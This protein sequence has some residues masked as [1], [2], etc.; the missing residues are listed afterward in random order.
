[1]KRFSSMLRSGLAVAALVVLPMT[2]VVA[3]AVFWEPPTS[4]PRVCDIPFTGGNVRV[5]A[6][7]GPV[8]TPFPITTSCPVGGGTCLEWRYQWQYTG[9]NPSQS[10]V[11]VDSNVRVLAAPGG[12]PI[13]P[14]TFNTSINYGN[15]GS[16]LGILYTSNAST[17]NAS[18]FTDTSA[19]IGTVTSG[20]K[21]GNRNGFCAIAG[22]NK[23]SSGNPDLSAPIAVVTTTGTCKVEWA[24]SKDGC[25][26]GVTVLPGS[27][28]SC[29]AIPSANG[30]GKVNLQN[31]HNAS[32]TASCS[33]EINAPGSTN[34]CRYNS[35]L[36]TY[37]CVTY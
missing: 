27:G 20:F 18:F 24:Q 32:T 16:E 17:F 1:M 11:G 7:P 21:S 15:V 28:P 10:M 2:T 25:V 34:V 30:S 14:T 23:S 3:Q 26:T 36:R 8:G 33:T 31:L 9:V 4:T 22:A 6:G 29:L 12:V 19:V 5:I 35:L 13:A 37:T